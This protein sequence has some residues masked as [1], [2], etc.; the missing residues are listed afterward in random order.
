M[1]MADSPSR[2]DA[3]RLAARW[4]EIWP[5][6][7]PFEEATLYHGAYDEDLERRGVRFH[8]LPASKQYPE[9]GAE[10]AQLLYRHH[11]LLDRLASHD[12]QLFLITKSWSWGP[13]ADPVGEAPKRE[14][15]AE[16]LL[17]ATDV[18]SFVTDPEPDEYGDIVWTHNYVSRISLADRSFSALL[19][20]G[21]DGEVSQAMIVPESMDWMFSPYAGGVDIVARNER[22]A[23]QLM[24]EFSEWLPVTESEWPQGIPVPD[25]D[26]Q[27]SFFITLENLEYSTAKRIV[28]WLERPELRLAQN[29]HMTDSR[30]RLVLEID[31]ADAQFVRVL[32]TG[33][34]ETIFDYTTN[35]DGVPGSADRPVVNFPHRELSQRSPDEARL[36][37][38]D[39]LLEDG[40]L[41]EFID[42]TGFRE[43]AEAIDNK[44]PRRHWSPRL[45][46]TGIDGD[47]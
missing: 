27:P 21:A 18:M 43:P 28:N 3:E 32:I 24:R 19:A 36:R 5:D 16:R 47:E 34:P 40:G 44:L 2:T 23:L 17:E 45:D 4:L 8:S 1:V 37:L 15:W 10:Y 26:S 30:D 31:R 14:E 35:L 29:V 12:D 13:A 7:V 38:S 6:S 46:Y 20:L 9:I 33:E 39:T 22:E 11:T 41:Q 25:F 42:E